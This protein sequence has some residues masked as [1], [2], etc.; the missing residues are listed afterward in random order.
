LSLLP[1]YLGEKQCCLGLP[2]VVAEFPA[3]LKNLFKADCGVGQPV[4]PPVGAGEPG[5]AVGLAR[6]VPQLRKDGIAA[7]EVAHGLWQVVLA[8]AQ[9]AQATQQRCLS[10]P[11]AGQP[12]GAKS[13]LVCAFP[14]VPA[15]IHLKKVS[16]QPRECL[17]KPSQAVAPCLVQAHR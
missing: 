5:Q 7:S 13:Y 6:E 17:P 10:V 8:A 11:V 14:L 16:K 1:A 3:K 4:L 2:V 15:G 9:V 12:G